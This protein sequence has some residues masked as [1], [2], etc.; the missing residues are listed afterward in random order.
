MF[1]VSP[2]RTF[3]HDVKIAMPIDDGF[4]DEKLKT[5]FNFLTSDEINELLG[6]DTKFLEKAVATF[7]D[8]VDDDKN[9][10]TCTPEIRASLLLNLNVQQ[11][12][13][14]HYFSAVRKVPQGN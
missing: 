4:A 13:I 14:A 11:G 9:P 3:T 10:V 6:D 5:T 7:H 12:L 8:L 2:K 1:N